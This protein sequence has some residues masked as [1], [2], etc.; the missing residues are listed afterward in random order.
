VD[1]V[2]VYRTGFSGAA[3]VTGAGSA[4]GVVILLLPATTLSSDSPL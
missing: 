1:L 4:L 2:A 3:A